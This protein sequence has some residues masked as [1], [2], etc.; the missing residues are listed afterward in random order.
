MRYL[1][2]YLDDGDGDGDV[3]IVLPVPAAYLLSSF[4]VLLASVVFRRLKFLE[5]DNYGGRGYGDADSVMNGDTSNSDSNKNYTGGGPFP[6][7]L[8]PFE[9]ITN[10][11][12]WDR[13]N[14]TLVEAY[15]YLSRYVCHHP[16]GFWATRHSG[17]IGYQGKLG[18]A[19]SPQKN[20]L[21]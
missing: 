17:E 6:P 8:S 1:S 10:D 16:R 3:G 21:F 18:R 15:D 13:S 11:T 12:E 20:E 4:I 14:P 2:C 9:R 19:V 5:Y 7:I